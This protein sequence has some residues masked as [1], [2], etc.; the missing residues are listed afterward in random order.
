M[1]VLFLILIVLFSVAIFLFIKKENYS[2]IDTFGFIVIRHVNDKQ[3]DNYWKESYR[4]IRLFYPSSKIIIIDDNS[5]PEYVTNIELTN[6]TIIQSEYKGRGE[7]LPYYYY[8]KLG[9]YWFKNAVILHDSVFIHKK[10]DLTS[11][12][13]AYKMLWTFAHDWDQIEDE[14]RIIN[15]LNNSDELLQFHKD[16]NKWTGCFGGMAI[17]S[18]EFLL[19]IDRKYDLS[20]LLVPITTRFNRCSFERVIA[21]LMHYHYLD[22]SKKPPK[23]SSNI[24]YGIIHDYCI[25]GYTFDEYTRD[26]KNKTINQN[27]SFV[28]VWTGR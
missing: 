28:K 4:C 27:T 23:N 21:C 3:T 15:H 26:L 24:L 16:K 20:K 17:I 10:I 6:T 1:K 25:W 22:Y 12:N 18:Y 9:K 7:L 2:S 19:S 8:A 13:G 14:T 5:N 11:D